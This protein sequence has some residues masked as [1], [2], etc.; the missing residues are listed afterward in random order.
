[1]EASTPGPRCADAQGTSLALCAGADAGDDWL[2]SGTE[3]VPTSGA[4]ARMEVWP[5]P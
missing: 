3:A 4:S 5:E 2:V 1:M